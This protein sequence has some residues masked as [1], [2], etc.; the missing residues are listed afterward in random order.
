MRPLGSYASSTRWL[1]AAGIATSVGMAH[2]E[3]IL[4]NQNE[5]PP[6]RDSAASARENARAQRVEENPKVPLSIIL[7]ELDDGPFSKHPGGATTDNR[8]RARSFQQGKDGSTATDLER[9]L[10]DPE[11]NQG[12]TKNNLDRARAYQRGESPGVTGTR[13]GGT[14]NLPLVDCGQV[15]S[16]S[17]RIG[18]DVSGAVIT[19]MRG[20]KALQVKC[21]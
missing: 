10:I 14:G 5:K 15:A 20:G 12:K 6:S 2:A 19:I 9:L 4:G 16:S 21:K 8:N 11:S 13:F 18:D 1:I 17:G 7:D 3:I